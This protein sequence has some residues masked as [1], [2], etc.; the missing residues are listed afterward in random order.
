MKTV[1][2]LTTLAALAATCPLSA[3]TPA[4]SKPSG[5]VTLGNQDSDPNT[6]DV[7]ANTDVVISGRICDEDNE[8]HT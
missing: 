7:P 1:I 8:K 3:Q 6:P 5:Y 2:P 4:Y